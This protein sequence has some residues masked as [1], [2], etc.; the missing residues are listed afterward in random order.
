MSQRRTQKVQSLVLQR[1]L[2]FVAAWVIF[3]IYFG[4]NLGV[5]LDWVSKPSFGPMC[6]FP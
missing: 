1:A 2:W 6:A 3:G 4:T 5:G